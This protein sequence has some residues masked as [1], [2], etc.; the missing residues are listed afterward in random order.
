MGKIRLE[1]MN[2]YAHHGYFEEEQKLG[3]RYTVDVELTVDFKEAAE[4]DLL[5]GTTD[6]VQVYKIVE[7]VMTVNTKLLEH[8]AFKINKKILEQ[9]NEVA[10]IA[11][12]VTKH[13]PPLGGLCASAS[14]SLTSQR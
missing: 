6:Y 7:Q 12:K 3:T 8:L 10:E 4:S 11:T 5:E 1:G 2:F 13:N 9:C 14:V